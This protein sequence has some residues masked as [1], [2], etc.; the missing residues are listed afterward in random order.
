MFWGSNWTGV[1][2]T[3]DTS[4][5]HT[6]NSNSH[7]SRQK[8]AGF[9]SQD[10][11]KSW[12]VPKVMRSEGMEGSWRLSHLKARVGGWALQQPASLTL[13]TV[14]PLAQPLPIPWGLSS[15]SPPKDAVPIFRTSPIFKWNDYIILSAHRANLGQI[16]THPHLTT[17]L[18]TQH[19][20]GFHFS[21]V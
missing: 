19:P 7:S 17:H 15:L 3:G 1:G 18:T 4:Q 13:D 16:L 14:S 2:G 12:V 20:G 11:S 9:L 8:G 5:L 6:P 10:V 21:H